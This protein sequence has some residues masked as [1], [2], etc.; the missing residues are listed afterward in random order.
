MAVLGCILID[1]KTMYQARSL[2]LTPEHFGTLAN[3]VIYKAMIDLFTDGH[4]IDL[5]T[6]RDRL[7]ARG[8]LASVGDVAYLAQLDNDMPDTSSFSSYVASVRAGGVRRAVEDAGR[9]LQRLP[10]DV[11]TPEE[12][13]G[14][15]HDSLRHVSELAEGHMRI[16]SG[17][18]AVNSLVEVLEEGMGQGIQTGFHGLDSALSGLR[19]GNLCIVA[20]R[21][22]MGKTSLAISMAANQMSQEVPLTP[23][24]FSLEMSSQELALMFLSRESGIPR[25]KLKLGALGKEEWLAIA[26]A[27]S[28]LAQRP[29]IIE[30]SGALTVGQIAAKAKELKNT[31]GIDIIYIDYLQLMSSDMRS[32]N[33]TE[34]VSEI[35]RGLKL[36]AKDLDVP[37]VALSQVNRKNEDR[38]DK[39]P[40]LQD[41]R[42]SGSLEQDADSVLFVYRDGYYKT[43]DTTHGAAEIIVAKNRSGPTGRSNVVWEPECSVFRNP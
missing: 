42:E 1:H 26:K 15:V 9:A 36:L 25:Q 34:Q 18:E 7:A 38:M 10:Q 3:R 40:G 22:G 30:D 23:C 21:P 31:K 8:A 19:G 35:S 17:A 16:T 37:I 32:S 27:R 43:V 24:I 41:L 39:R 14:A 5:I 12:L 13:I 2:G 29:L 11:E 4:S 28:A 20:G 6:V 33:R